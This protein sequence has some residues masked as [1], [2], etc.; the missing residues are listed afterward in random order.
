[1]RLDDRARSRGHPRE[2]AM[3]NT[4]GDRYSRRDL[5]CRFA[6]ANE[7][8][9]CT[10]RIAL[11]VSSARASARASDRRELVLDRGLKL[12]R[13]HNAVK[14][15]VKTTKFFRHYL[16]I[17][18]RSFTIF[19]FF[20]FC[21]VG[22]CRSKHSLELKIRYEASLSLFLSL[23]LSLSLSPSIYIYIYLYFFIHSAYR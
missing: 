22:Y 18:R 12:P 23:S 1:M 7:D 11:T 2:N 15:A 21:V 16:D 19:L 9:K 20:F 4:R 5:A 13:Q 3:M 17:F 14:E 8:V 10:K 6:R